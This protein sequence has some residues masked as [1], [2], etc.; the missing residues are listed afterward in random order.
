MKF[1]NWTPDNR[2]RAPVFLGLRN[3]VAAPREVARERRR[4]R[5][6][7]AARRTPKEATLDIDGQHA[8]VHQPE[9][10]LLSRRRL[11]QARR[12]ELLRRRGR[13]DSAAPE[14]PP[15]LAE[16]LPQRHQGGVSSSRRTRPRRFAPWLR[17]ELIDSDHTGKPIR[18]VFA[19]G[20][21]QPALPG[22]PG[23]HRPQSVDEPRRASLDNPD[24]VLID[25][26][27]Q[28]CPFD[29]IVDAALLVKRVLDRIGLTGYPKTTGGDGMHVYIPRRAGLH[30][31]GDAHV[32]RADRAPGD[33]TRSPTCSPRRARSRSGR[34]TAC[35]STTC[36]TASRRPSPRRTCC[37]PTPG[38]PVATPLGVERSE[39]RACIPRSSTSRTRASG[40]AR[41]ATCSRA[42]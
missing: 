2:L 15:A 13:P 1:A 29:M 8:E 19:R 35:I 25:L 20:P 38:A 41:R 7:T 24:F 5:R 34:R 3:D 10:G 30:L 16:A 40:F 36:R 12:P 4:R 33:R 14:G 9:E 27:P 39:A 26:D 6:A 18:Y 11:H 32:R 31:R 42:C 28:E 37:A 21:R 23:L 22:E 17:T